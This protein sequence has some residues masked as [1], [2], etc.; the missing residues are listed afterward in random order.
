[1]KARIFKHPKKRSHRLCVGESDDFQQLRSISH[2]IVRWWKW[3]FSTAKEHF[4]RAISWWKQESHVFYPCFENQMMIRSTHVMQ[5]KKDASVK[6]GNDGNSGL[7]VEIGLQSGSCSVTHASHSWRR[8]WKIWIHY[9]RDGSCTTW[10]TTS[11]RFNSP[12][13]ITHNCMVSFQCWKTK[14][15]IFTSARPRPK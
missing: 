6:V 8:K 3:Q 11:N 15:N 14:P 10:L 4:S 12:T 9:R 7:H 13:H 2:G 1:M 5:I